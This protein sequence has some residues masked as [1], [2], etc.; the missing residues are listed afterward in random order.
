[1]DGLQDLGIKDLVKEAEKVYYKRETEEEKEQ[2][3]EK[4]KEEKQRQREKRQEKQLTRILAA[5]VGGQVR[6]GPS[7]QKRQGDRKGTNLG[8]S[9]PPLDRDQCAYCKEK[10]HWKNECPNK[11]REKPILALNEDSD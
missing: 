6:P 2:R 4:E 11:G 5:A 7:K 8:G 3:L 9:R 1:M 10:G